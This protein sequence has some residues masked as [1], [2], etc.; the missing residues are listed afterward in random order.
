MHARSGLVYLQIWLKKRFTNC[1]VSTI[2]CSVIP[3]DLFDYRASEEQLQQHI[4]VQEELTGLLRERGEVWF[5][6]LRICCSHWFIS[7]NC[8]FPYSLSHDGLVFTWFW[9]LFYRIRICAF[10]F[11]YVI[12]DFLCCVNCFDNCFA[13]I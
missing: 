1:S 13:Y 4:K 8:A 5:V 11:L 10:I 12:S 7:H 6:S 9:W 3:I 2:A